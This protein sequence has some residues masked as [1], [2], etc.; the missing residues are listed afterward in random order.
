M[1][2]RASA[3]AVLCCAAFASPV[4]CAAADGG[5]PA[6]EIRPRFLMDLDPA[7]PRPEVQIGLAPGQVRLMLALRRPG[8]R[9]AA[10]GGAGTLHRPPARLDGGRMPG[11]SR[12]SVS[13]EAT[14]RDARYAAADAII[15]LDH[16]SSAPLLHEAAHGGDA[17]LRWLIEPALAE[18]G[19]VPI[20]AE[21][22]DRL[23]AAAVGRRELLLAIRGS[24]A[25]DD[26]ESLAAL[27][28][29]VHDGDRR[30]DVRLA[31]A[32]SAG[33]IATAELA[34]DARQLMAADGLSIAPLMAVRLLA[35]HRTGEA[36]GLLEELARGVN[37][38]VVEQALGILFEI[39]PERVLPLAAAALLNFDPKVRLRGVEAYVAR[40]NAERV[41]SLARLLDDSHPD[42]RGRVREALFQL[43]AQPELDEAVR[44]AG[45]IV[46]AGDAW[47]GQEQAALL[48]GA[49]DHEPAVPRLMELLHVERPEVMVAAAWA[50]KT[51]GVQESLPQLL[52][53]ARQMTDARRLSGRQGL[54]EQLAHLFEAMGR[55]Q[56]R[57]AE[58]LLRE[59]VPKVPALGYYSR[60]AAIWSLG[61]LHE[62]EVD[63][64][65]AAQ[66]VERMNDTQ[67]LMPDLDIV[68]RMSAITLG[69]MQ[70]R[71]SVPA[72]EERLRSVVA[73]D[74]LAYAIRW[75]L[76]EIT[77]I[78]LPLPGPILQT[79]TGWFLEPYGAE[80]GAVG[81]AAEE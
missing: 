6:D 63:E 35:R 80:E 64:P 21:W 76:M 40:P 49:L 12:T 51:V 69:R 25:A 42:V 11:R 14:H 28:K 34:A 43:A 8:T 24:A 9:H 55:M 53:Y 7:F 68:W 18:W 20:R 62:G 39:D 23:A 71:S 79:R 66:L 78:S 73:H 5:A 48:L 70:A 54:D 3:I 22:R 31:A 1:R 27:L 36:A 17:A 81:G 29:I 46:L 19:F 15:A 44:T 33:E 16:R 2:L 77:G 59:Y 61:L 57:P 10:T 41:H 56:Y 67:P 30:P 13:A 37:P 4:C 58:G 74:P 60:G 45:A 38:A 65:L 32:Q 75:S 52:E 47:R 50:L 26:R 72:L